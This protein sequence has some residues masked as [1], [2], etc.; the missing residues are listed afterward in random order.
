VAK[1][2]QE[3]LKGESPDAG[4]PALGWFDHL[5]EIDSELKQHG[6]N[7]I[8]FAG[9]CDLDV[10]SIESASLQLLVKL[11]EIRAMSKRGVSA[12]VRRRLVASEGLIRHMTLCIVEILFLESEPLPEACAVLLRELLGGANTDLIKRPRP[13][14]K[15]V[16]ELAVQ[17]LAQPAKNWSQNVSE[18]GS[19]CPL[20]D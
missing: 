9:V 4:I 14:T 18:G 1:Y 15:I 17:I 10:K 7:A 3:R 5:F 2:V 8:D 13:E 19:C 6:I 11:G 16:R 12:A 20:H